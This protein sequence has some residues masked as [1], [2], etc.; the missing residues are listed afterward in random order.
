MDRKGNIML[1]QGLPVEQRI[2]HGDHLILP[3]MPQEGRRRLVSDHL[4]AGKTKL[5]FLRQLFLAQQVPEAAKM[6]ML[7]VC[8]NGQSQF[9]VCEGGYL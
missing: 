9:P 6:G 3:G 7:R 8:G 5:L 1:C 4:I 2:H